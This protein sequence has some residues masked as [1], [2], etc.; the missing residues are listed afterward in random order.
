MA[1]PIVHSIC[2]RCLASHGTAQRF[3]IRTAEVKGIT[4]TVEDGTVTAWKVKMN[5][6]FAVQERLHE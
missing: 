2:S 6:T 1:A 4:A 5:V 3:G